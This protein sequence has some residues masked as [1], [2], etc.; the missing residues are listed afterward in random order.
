LVS[1]ACARIETQPINMIAASQV[2]FIWTSEKRLGGVYHAPK[3]RIH[4]DGSLRDDCARITT[5]PEV[6]QV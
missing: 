1:G 6:L 4:R 2:F 5:Q 3:I